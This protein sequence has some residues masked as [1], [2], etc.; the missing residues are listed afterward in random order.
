MGEGRKP[1]QVVVGHQ[2]VAGQ[3]LGPGCFKGLA[4]FLEALGAGPIEVNPRLAQVHEGIE[5][6]VQMLEP[7]GE[8]ANGPRPRRGAVRALLDQQH[9]GL[10]RPTLQG[11]QDLGAFGQWP[12][13]GGDQAGV[14][15]LAGLHGRQGGA[16]SWAAASGTEAPLAT[17]P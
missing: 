12:A 5:L 13:V 1:G 3:G 16:P 2:G 17:S 6:R 4:L 15:V 14:L 8:L 11:Q 10:Q 9:G 7:A